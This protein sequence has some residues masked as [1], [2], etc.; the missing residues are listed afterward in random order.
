MF[1]F[2]NYN[3]YFQ[4]FN[5]TVSVIVFSSSG[6]TSSFALPSGGIGGTWSSSLSECNPRLSFQVFLK[7]LSFS[8]ELLKIYHNELC[9]YLEAHYIIQKLY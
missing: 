7:Y 8:F 9:V 6:F 5:L 2:F 3:Y 4:R 1:L